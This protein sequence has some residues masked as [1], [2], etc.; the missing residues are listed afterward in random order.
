MF[1]RKN[2]FLKKVKYKIQPLIILLD[3]ALRLVK[4]NILF[5][6]QLFKEFSKNRFKQR[7]VHFDITHNSKRYLFCLIY[8]FQENNYYINIS[9]SPTVLNSLKNDLSSKEIFNQKNVRL[10]W[11][12]K[13]S[14]NEIYFSD[15]KVKVE[16]YNISYNYFNLNSKDIIYRIPLTFHHQNLMQNNLTL[17]N[18]NPNNSSRGVNLFFI[19]NLTSEF[20]QNRQLKESFNVMTRMEAI[21]TICENFDYTKLLVPNS[22]KQLYKGFTDKMDIILCDGKANPVWNR[23]Y[24]KLLEQANFFLAAS[25]FIMPQC[26]NII[27]AMA[28]GCIPLIEYGDWFTPPLEH[29]VNAIA[30]KGSEDLVDKIKYI[31]TLTEI[32]IAKLRQG[33]LDYYENN[34]TS[35][36]VIQHILNKG[37]TKLYLNSESYSV[38]LMQKNV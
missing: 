19:G 26:H 23:D 31:L 32:D 35:K 33:V 7:S 5:L 6:I 12:R 1:L 15:T 24:F 10:A 22:T 34:L 30:F 29:N 2:D 17:S 37:Y 38:G 3:S 11:S 36:S 14:L 13:P 9:C 16:E 18:I 8:F 28:A 25:G 4:F 21:N 27:E 20:Y